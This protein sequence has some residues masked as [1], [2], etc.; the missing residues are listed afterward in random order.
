MP[1]SESWQLP[2]DRMLKVRFGRTKVFEVVGR[3]L[4]QNQAGIVLEASSE[5]DVYAGFA[6]VQQFVPYGSIIEVEIL[7]E[8]SAADELQRQ[9]QK[10]ERVSRVQDELAGILGQAASRSASQEDAPP[11]SRTRRKEPATPPPPPIAEPAPGDGRTAAEKLRQRRPGAMRR[12][13]DDK[14]KAGRR[15]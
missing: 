5:T 8:Q 3:C 15:E 12:K 10:V 7:G 9:H 6:P 4:K 1:Q 11:P 2:R 13:D 14:G